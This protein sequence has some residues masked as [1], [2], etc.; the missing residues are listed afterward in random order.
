MKKQY[1]YLIGFSVATLGAVVLAYFFRDEIDEKYDYR[2]ELQLL[3]LDP[4][5]RDKVRTL[6][7]RARK[8][9]M[10]L[11]VVEGHRSCERQNKLFAQGRTTPGKVVTNA[12]CG[13]SPHNFKL[14]GIGAADV[15]EFKNG[16]ILF[17]NPNWD[18]IGELAVAAGLEW[19]GN[20]K[21]FKDRPHVQ[22]LGGRSISSLFREFQANRHNAKTAP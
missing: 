22:D 7:K 12:R 13:Q 2:T 1:W 11:R 16:K 19:G 21:S 14:P 6:L 18:R 15:Y 3:S 9:G 20:W 10:D 17:E 5:F 8:E 4:I